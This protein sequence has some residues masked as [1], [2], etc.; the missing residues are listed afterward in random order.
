MCVLMMF[1]LLIYINNSINKIWN[2]NLG[3]SYVEDVEI[4]R[5]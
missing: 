2:K 5:L 1:K 4:D 3:K